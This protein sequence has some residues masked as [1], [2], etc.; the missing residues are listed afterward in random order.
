MQFNYK[1]M[2]YSDSSNNYFLK[3]H[4]EF[5]ANIFICDLFMAIKDVKPY[6]PGMNIE[7]SDYTPDTINDYLH[8]YGLKIKDFLDYLEYID[9]YHDFDLKIM[10]S[11][12]KLELKVG[13]FENYIYLTEDDNQNCIKKINELLLNDINFNKIN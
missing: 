10:T 2:Q 7:L 9:E 4:E 11:I 5:P 12:G 6:I 1:I 8:A 3:F 13:R